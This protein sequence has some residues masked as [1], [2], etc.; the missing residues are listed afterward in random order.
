MKK[1]IELAN[2]RH[3]REGLHLHVSGVIH[4]EDESGATVLVPFR[5]RVHESDEPARISS[6]IEKLH[7]QTSEWLVHRKHFDGVRGTKTTHQDNVD[8]HIIDCQLAFYGPNDYRL[9]LGWI[10]TIDGIAHKVRKTYRYYT[11]AQ[12]MSAE[13][14]VAIVHASINER[15]ANSRAKDIV[16]HVR[17]LRAA[18]VA[19]D[20][21]S[22]VY[23]GGVYYEY[24]QSTDTYIEREAPEE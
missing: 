12:A 11:P 3:S 15:I 22:F 9:N 8:T 10:E 7:A 17:S 23:Q 13:E 16:S 6:H 2:L 21:P 19:K 18:H 4:H 24:E 14:A 1:E 5:L 20:K